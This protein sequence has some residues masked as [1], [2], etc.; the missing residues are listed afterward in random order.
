MESRVSGNAH[1]R[2]GVGENPEVS[3]PK[4]YLSLYID[5]INLF[6]TR[7]VCNAVFCFMNIE[8]MNIPQIPRDK[9]LSIVWIMLPIVILFNIMLDFIKHLHG[10]LHPFCF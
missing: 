6:V 10:F 7:T 1:A 2:F 3:S 5:S 4:D 8:I 9:T